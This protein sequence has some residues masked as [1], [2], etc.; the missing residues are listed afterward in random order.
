MDN[1]QENNAMEGFLFIATGKKYIQEAVTSAKRIRQIGC[2]TPIT[3]VCDSKPND[4][5][6]FDDIRVE[7]VNINEAGFMYKARQLASIMPYDRTFFL[8]S[9]TYMIE[10]CSELFQ[11]LDFFDVC[12]THCPV[13]MY[14]VYDS[15]GQIVKGCYPYNSGVMV[16][17]RNEKTQQLFNRL[18]QV[19]TEHN[20]L[21]WNDQIALMEAILYTDVRIYV[22]QSIY[23][24][25]TPY[26]QS[27]PGLKVKIIHG[28]V[29]N[30]EKTAKA[31]NKFEDKNRV[32]IPESQTVL[33]RNAAWWFRLYMVM[34]ESVHSFFKKLFHR[35]QQ[36]KGK[37]KN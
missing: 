7:P 6:I 9:D 15:G 35:I 31:I 37:T 23:N 19:F 36:L 12:M 14:K 33:Y 27:F 3:L 13:D 10:D 24:F 2:K 25:R 17:K 18:L 4:E 16:Y 21:Y 20:H 5:G 8:D 11:L 29:K 34:P 28:R 30:F 26:V 22:L 32:W 1:N